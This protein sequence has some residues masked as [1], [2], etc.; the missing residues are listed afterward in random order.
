MIIQLNTAD[1]SG[2]N[3][4]NMPSIPDEDIGGSSKPFSDLMYTF[5]V[6]SDIHLYVEGLKDSKNNA[7]IKNY[8]NNNKF[9]N[10][11]DFMTEREIEDVYIAGDIGYTAW[12]GGYD[13][14]CVLEL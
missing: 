5:G 13:E 12:S 7:T 14:N 9:R 8:D 2:N 3:I 4:N 10:A 1:F 6:L 11:I